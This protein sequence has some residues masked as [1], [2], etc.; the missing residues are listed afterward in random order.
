MPSK[1]FRRSL[2]AS[3]AVTALVGLSG[4]VTN[5]SEHPGHAEVRGQVTPELITLDEREID[6]DN[7]IGITN[8]A[9]LRMLWMDLRRAMLLDRPSRLTPYP[10]AY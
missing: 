7:R 2:L 1:M 9:N 3:A 6:S 8:N 10:M 5:Y 4:C